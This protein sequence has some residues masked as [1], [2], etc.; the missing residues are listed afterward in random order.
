M[1]RVYP[2]DPAVLDRTRSWLFKQQAADGCWTDGGAERKL[3]LTS[4]V[5]W[6]MAASGLHGPE[7]QRAVA[8]VRGNLNSA[9]STYEKALAANALAAWNSKDP[10]LVTLLKD[11]ESRKKEQKE[12]RACCFPSQGRSLANAWGDSRTVETTALVAL[13]LLKTNL[14]PHTASGALV[15]LAQGRSA[16]GDW[17]STQATV[18]ALKALSAS[19][20]RSPQKGTVNVTILVHGQPVRKAEVNEANADVLQ[21]FDLTEYLRPGRNEVSLQVQG[22]T[23]LS[24]QVLGRHYLPWKARQQQDAL[25][26]LAV[27]YPRTRLTTQDRLQARA[28]LKYHG[29]EPT[30][31]VMVELG[32]PPGFETDPAEFTALVEANKVKRFEA[33][34]GQLTLYLGDVPSN[35]NQ[36]FAYTLRPKYPLRAKTPVSVAYEY[37]TPASRTTAA[38]VELLVEDATK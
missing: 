5:A 30:T 6:A 22:E 3:L 26:E 35:S 4:Y 8:Y 16:Y 15:Y 11:L 29:Q 25:L 12:T 21:V 13:A 36:A 9:T 27:Y 32:V 19:A 24:Y 23:D 33:S 2:V 18:L 10:A 14:Y 17:G 28:V 20:G 1:A 38:P 7:V 31:S 37:Y 34:P